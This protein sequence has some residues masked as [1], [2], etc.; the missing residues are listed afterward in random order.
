MKNKYES[1]GLFFRNFWLEFET[2]ETFET[3]TE[4][5]SEKS[6]YNFRSPKMK[7]PGK[8]GAV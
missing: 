7:E 4:I 5:K 8:K 3:T 2:N 6:D 1:H